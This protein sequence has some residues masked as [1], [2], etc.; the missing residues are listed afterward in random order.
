[1]KSLLIVI[2]SAVAGAVLHYGVVAIAASA[3]LVQ[4]KGGFIAPS[5]DKTFDYLVVAALGAL[6]GLVVAS[7]LLAVSTAFPP[8]FASRSGAALVV[9]AVASGNAALWTW[10]EYTNQRR[11]AP[12]AALDA[13]AV[14]SVVTE[15]G[16]AFVFG[17]LLGVTV[18]LLLH[19]LRP[20][21]ERL[22]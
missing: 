18:V 16:I 7:L 21:G 6:A 13:V 10:L 12:G 2:C 4:L 15:G 9:A 1:M 19:W 17:L 11:I 20:A 22:A 8:L 5:E 3:G 14:K